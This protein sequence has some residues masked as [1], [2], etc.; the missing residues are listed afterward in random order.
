M[1]ISRETWV[2]AAKDAKDRTLASK[3]PDGIQRVDNVLDS[4]VNRVEQNQSIPTTRLRVVPRVKAAARTLAD[5]I[6]K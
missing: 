3:H 5:K 1:M 6:A 2:R 4:Q